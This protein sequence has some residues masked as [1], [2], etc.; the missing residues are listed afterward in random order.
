MARKELC[1]VKTA[2]CFRAGLT[3]LSFA[4]PKTQALKT[5]GNSRAH[6]R[7]GR[8]PKGPWEGKP[9]G[10]GTRG[11][12]QEPYGAKGLIARQPERAQEPTFRD[13]LRSQGPEREE[14]V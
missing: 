11:P 10:D 12:K 7:N 2:V 14:L 1:K 4:S 13:L 3:C 9:L 8:Q 5:Q 6:E